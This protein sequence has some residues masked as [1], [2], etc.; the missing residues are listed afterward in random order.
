M[1]DLQEALADAQRRHVAI[2]H[3]NATT[4]SMIDAVI[5][6]ALK[7]NVPVIVGFS[8][9]ERLFFGLRQAVLYVKS[10]REQLNH[11]IFVNAD[12]TYSLE[13]A[14]EAIDVG[15]DSVVWDGAEKPY[16]E[17]RDIAKLVVE[18]ARAAS[19][20]QN[21]EILVEAEL[22]FIGSGSNIKEIPPEGAVITEEHM[23]EPEEAERFVR[24]T[25]VDLL[26]PAVGNLHGVLK[27]GK[28]PH[29]NPERV[30]AIRKMAGVPLVLHGGSG[31]S[32]D[33]FRKGIKAGIAQIHV[34][35]ELRIA[36]RKALEATLKD[37]PDELA[38][39]HYMQP[40]REAVQKV[41]EDKLRLFNDL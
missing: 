24:Q 3:F 35:T 11:P 21:K 34:S 39:Y 5:K 19:K 17:N 23:T 14:K 22:G 36:Y 10:V 20:N 6:A 32:D 16:E 38:P 9:G 27:G 7:L 18:Y 28:N 33:D 15:F 1:M 26:A 41:V 37:N 29:I 8:E 13:R 12:H 25:G 4:V 40:V 2:G 30:T 31:I